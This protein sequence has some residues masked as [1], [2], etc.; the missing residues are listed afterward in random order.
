MAWTDRELETLRKLA[1]TDMTYAEIGERLGR[2]KSTV[3]QKARELNLPYRPSHA[4]GPGGN[5]RKLKAPSS[6]G[7]SPRGD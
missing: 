7:S 1:L 2:R 6:A 5:R 3:A 4:L